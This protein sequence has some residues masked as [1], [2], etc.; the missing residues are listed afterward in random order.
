MKR[1]FVVLAVVIVLFAC[2]KSVAPEEP[3]IVEGTGN[4]TRRSI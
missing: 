1:I 3:W 4:K 2:Q